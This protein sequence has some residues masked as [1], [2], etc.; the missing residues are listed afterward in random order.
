MGLRDDW[1]FTLSVVSGGH[2]LSHFYLLA[3]PPLFPLIR[4]EF[5]LNNTELGLLVSVVAAAGLLQA[6]MGDVVDRVGG[7]WVFVAGVAVSGAG[8]ALVG[9][10]PTYLAM[11]PIA[12]ITGV[13]QSTFH[14]A[15][16]TLLEA[17]T[18][19]GVEG[20]AF[21]VHTFCGYA[22]FAAAPVVV[23]ALG[24]SFGWRWALF[25]VGAVGPVYAL[26][27]A[28]VLVPAARPPTDEGAGATESAAGTG[29][30]GSFVS[31]LRNPGILA[32]GGFFLLAAF[33]GKGIQT[34]TTVLAVETFGLA[35]TVGN[36]ALTAFFVLGALGVLSGGVLADRY[37]PARV[38]AAAFALGA[39]LV[40]V[41]VSGLVP[42][43]ASSLVGL[44]AAAGF[45]VA[46]VSPSR[47]R[48][49]SSL[50]A[51]GSIGRSF[52]VVFAGGTVGALIGPAFYGVVG[53]VASISLSFV[54]VGAVY[55]L[56]ALVV[57]ALGSGVLAVAPQAGPIEGD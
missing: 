35:E 54:L 30:S 51:S 33:A 31:A 1:R 17:V 38:I 14:P 13:G 56:A 19:P 28:A 21:S 16:Y 20:R 3:F 46:L 40:V 27:A 26:V 55:G 34:F 36:T 22:G 49:V 47:D 25:I 48:L 6:P 15:D 7:K 45:F 8:I 43:T 57:L 39:A 24:L 50:S 52:G 41:T 5:A 4:R 2:F 44:Y 18:D 29:L 53:D 23:G 37:R 42:I 12:V 9:L 10:A 32:M 11:L